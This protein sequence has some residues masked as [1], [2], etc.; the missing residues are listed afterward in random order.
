M[1]DFR[2]TVS[3]DSGKSTMRRSIAFKCGASLIAM[4]GMAAVPAFAQTATTAQDSTATGTPLSNSTQT[5]TLPQQTPA[6]GSTDII[7]TGIRASLANSQEIKRNADTV[8][9]AI[10]ASDIGALPDRSVTEALQRVPGIAINRFSG[11]ND[12]DH[13]SAE[14]S[15]V[16]VRGLNFVR[17]EFN[18]RDAFSAGV[19]GQALNFAD[20]PAELLGSVEIFK[21]ATAENIEGGLA[22][23]VNLNTRKPFDN[24]G[25]HMAFDAE[26]NYGDFEKKWSPTGSLLISNTWN[27]G[28]GTIG[29]LA[30]ASYSELKYRSDGIQV[31]NI[32]ARDNALAIGADTGD[33]FVCRNPLPSSDDSFSLPPAGSPC[34][35]ASTAGSDGRGDLLDSAYAPLGGQFRTQDFDRKRDGEAAAFQWKSNDEKTL[36][37]AQFIRSHTELQWG[38]HTFESAPDLSDYDTYPAGCVQNGDGPGALPKGNNP[39][40]TT[41]AECDIDSATGNF[42]YP[43]NARGNGYNPDYVNGVLTTTYPNYEYDSTGLF[44]KGLITLP[45]SGWRTANSGSATTFVPTGGVQQSLS[46]RQVDE[47][48]TNTDFGLNLKAQPADHL[49][50]N[51]DADYTRSHHTQLDVSTFGSTFAD[52][53]LD[54]TGKV[55]VVIPHKPLTLS[56]TWAAPNP[57]LAADTDAQYF[58]DPNVQ[59]W[60]A[61]MDHIEDSVGTEY[62]FKADFKRTFDDSFLQD[63]KFG[64][65]YADRVEDVKYSAYNW[66]VLSEIWGGSHPESIADV[67]NGANAALYNFPDFFRGKT[68]APPSAYYYTGDLIGGYQSAGDFL[69][70]INQ[71]W[72]ADGGSAGWVPAAERA[73]VV[74]GSGGY[75]PNEIQNVK[76]ANA[77]LYLQADYHGS[78]F[79]K[80]ISGNIGLRY[81]NT[82]VR[83][84]GAIFVTAQNLGVNQTYASRCPDPATQQP[85]PNAPP[86]TVI[87]GGSAGVC[88]LGEAGYRDL[89]TFAGVLADGVTP[90]PGAAGS[91]PNTAYTGDNHFLPSFNLKME[92]NNSLIARFA[93]SRVMTLPDMASIR[94]SLSASLSQDN[95]ITF[96]LGNPYLKP[97]TATQFDATLEWY[98]ARVGSLTVD[99]FYKDVQNFFY[100][101][102]V[103]RNFTQNGIT[104]PITVRIADNYSG[105]GHI[106][107]AEIAY[108]QVFTFLPG[109]LKGFGVNAS[110]TYLDSSGLPNSFLNTGSADAVSNIKPGNLPLEQ[111]SK[112][113][114]NVEGFYERGPL[115]LRVAYN[116][117]SKFL[118]TASDVIFPYAPIF[119]A[120]TGQLDGSIFL[121][122]GKHLKIGVQGVNLLDEV[123]KTLQAY[124]GDPDQLAPRS[125]FINDRRYSFILRGSF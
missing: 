117:R 58:A 6:T 121:N 124:N 18:G 116:W 74:P 23:T 72:I 27:T 91:T 3:C 123:T 102:T 115:S 44:E 105:H 66:G 114:V 79:G 59:F 5:N 24:K 86:G 26:G 108:Q 112:H 1:R 101:S 75:L 62:A 13:F 20:V 81:V 7:V 73:G 60:R 39:T 14:G 120:A 63:I 95:V 52:E 104:E 118:L 83:S 33:T 40:S 48:N 36:L 17:S 68:S 119:N 69:K 125:Y 22:G 29:F 76:Q 31:T 87:A 111:L 92:L 54:L 94:N 90:L 97:A 71:Q 47:T 100:A 45:G 82:D 4:C 103:Q 85:P 78:L 53:Y 50:V 38:E 41:R 34:G 61:A 43:N 109:F 49:F 19:G 57:E 98:F 110:Y 70:S 42:Y 8:V 64:A 46:R 9:D 122:I 25:F 10:T 88:R 67:G 80:R 30:D 55:P 37:T 93:A 21:N 16:T 77:D 96:T 89:Q 113:T 12:P 35:T 107:G 11:S 99:V 28:I 65:R 32:Q 56:A 106:K 2:A 84:A 15:G 51:L